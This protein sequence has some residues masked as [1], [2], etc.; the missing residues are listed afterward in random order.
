V[1]KDDPENRIFQKTLLIDNPSKRKT[2]KIPLKKHDQ[3]PSRNPNPRPP[4]QSH[5]V[6]LN[7]SKLLLFSYKIDFFYP[8]FL[9]KKKSYL[10]EKKICIIIL[11]KYYFYR[12]FLRVC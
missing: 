4:S 2:K 3:I 12:N 1:E 10:Y 5:I 6:T 11:S 7:I 9:N 8:V